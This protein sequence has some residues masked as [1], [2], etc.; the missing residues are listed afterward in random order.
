M[1]SYSAKLFIIL[2]QGFEAFP[3]AGWPSPVV[4]MLYPL[5]PWVGVMA[6]GYAFGSFYQLDKQLRRRL[7]L[8][9]RR[10]SYRVVHQHALRK[11]LR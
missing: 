2:H 5:I 4:F 11:F 6:A 8:D 10:N 3:I 1:P 7:L 9:H